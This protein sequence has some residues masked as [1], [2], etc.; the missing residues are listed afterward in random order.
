M[1]YSECMNRFEISYRPRSAD[2]SIM[3]NG[4]DISP[5]V[6][7]VT[8][9]QNAGELPTVIVRMT[10][11]TEVDLSAVTPRLEMPAPMR[12]LLLAAGWTPPGEGGTDSAPNP[13]GIR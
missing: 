10:G 4:Q 3:L 1:S 9:N 5:M 12:A 2:S 13:G 7:G 8:V 6:Q 11:L